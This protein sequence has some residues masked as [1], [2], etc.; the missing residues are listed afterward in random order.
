MD[1]N[2]TWIRLYGH[3]CSDRAASQ[4]HERHGGVST[5]ILARSFEHHYC[6]FPDSLGA[7]LVLQHVQ[8]AA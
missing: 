7:S 8:H 2:C 3:D 1:M 6:G 5:V 4:D